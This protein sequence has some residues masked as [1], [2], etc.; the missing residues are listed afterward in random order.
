[1]LKNDNQLAMLFTLALTRYNSNESKSNNYWVWN[2]MNLII[3]AIGAS[4]GGLEAIS[5]LLTLLTR[6]DDM[7]FVVLQHLSPSHRSMMAEILQRSTALSVK[8]MEDQDEPLPNMVFVVPAHKNAG[9]ENGR[10]TLSAISQ[11]NN[12]KPSINYFLQH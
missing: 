10:F 8:E 1:M 3:T 12:P 4:A 9:F 6:N 7:C 11:P 5:A 2:S